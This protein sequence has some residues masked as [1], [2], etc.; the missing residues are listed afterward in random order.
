MILVYCHKSQDYLT[1][2]TKG[3]PSPFATDRDG[4]VLGML[5]RGLDALYATEDSN[6]IDRRRARVLELVAARRVFGKYPGSG[7]HLRESG[8]VEVHINGRPF[9]N[10]L[11][12]VCF[13]A[14]CCD[15]GEFY[16]CKAGRQSAEILAGKV[17]M[18]SRLH[19]SVRNPRTPTRTRVGIISFADDEFVREQVRAC[20]ENSHVEVF[21]EVGFAT[22]LPLFRVCSC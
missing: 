11:L 16:D 17:S 18:L 1:A 10:G 15:Q 3:W 7:N 6:L 14:R 2:K 13:W 20:P 22:R 8:D 12:D 9:G 4:T 5:E 19:S 21:G